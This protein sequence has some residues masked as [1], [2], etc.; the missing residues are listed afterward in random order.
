MS[1]LFSGNKG[2]IGPNL[3]RL[4]VA[5]GQ[6]PKAISSGMYGRDWK[7]Y[8]ESHLTKSFLKFRSILKDQPY[9]PYNA[10]RVIC[11]DSVAN[12]LVAL[13]Q[14]QGQPGIYKSPMGCMTSSQSGTAGKR[15]VDNQEQDS[16]KDSGQDK[17]VTYMDEAEPGPSSK[18][19]KGIYGDIIW[20]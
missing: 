9:G 4:G 17:P 1:Y 19:T 12:L 11:G 3:I 5:W 8:S 14:C 7:L 16:D 20:S 15:K 13:G 18:R 6:G 2:I 10:V